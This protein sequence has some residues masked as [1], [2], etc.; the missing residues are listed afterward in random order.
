[1]YDAS[2][3]G[4]THTGLSVAGTM[5]ADPIEVRYTTQTL[6]VFVHHE[7]DQVRGYTGNVGHA[8]V[9]MSDLV[10][11]DLRRASANEGRFTSP[12]S[13]DDWDARANT[14]DKDG[15][16]TFAHLPADMDIVV[17]AEARDGY[18]LLDLETLDTYRNMGEN[19]VVGG[20]FGA[21][22]GWGHTVALCPLEEIEPTGQDFGDCASFGV[23]SLHGVTAD[24]SKMSVGKSGTGFSDPS[25]SRQ[26][27]VT[28]SLSPAEGKNLAGVG[29]SFTT[30]SS[31]DPSTPEDD[32]RAHNFGAMAAGSYELGLTDGW[33]AMA[34]D[35]KAA[36]ALDPLG[37]DVDI[38]VTPT[39]TTL[40]GF[41]RDQAGFGLKDVPV[42]VNGQA[43]A[44]DDLG[45]YLATG[46]ADAKGKINV[47][48]ARAG[49]PTTKKDTAFVA[50]M[51]TQLNITVS[52]AN[53]TVAITGTVT[54]SGT[55]APLK[56]VE[57][58]VD[59]NAPLN[60]TGGKLTT[61]DDG[62]YT[63]LVVT[64]P[65]NDPLVSVSPRKAGYHFIP[66]SSPV[67]A[68]AGAN[69][70][71]NFTGYAAT[72]IVG[73]VTAP[74]GGMPRAEVTVTAY[75]DADM[76][77][78]LDDA[79]TTE[80][81]TFSVF[82]PTLSGTVYL[83]AEPRDDY[84]PSHPNFLALRDAERY[85]WFDA[86]DNRPGG[87]IAVIPGQTLQFGTFTGNSVQ[88][89]IAS[90][91]RVT[92]RDAFEGEVAATAIT[93]GTAA[94]GRD[95][96]ETFLLVQGE[97]TDTVVVTWHYETRNN[98]GTDLDPGGVDANPYTAVDAADNAVLETALGPR[99]SSFTPPGGGVTTPVSAIRGTRTRG[100]PAGTPGRGT[101]PAANGTTVRHD[102]ITQ[103]IIPEGDDHDY[104]DIHITIGHPVVDADGTARDAA[105]TVSAAEALAGVASGASG[106]TVDRDIGGGSGGAVV[107]DEITASWSGAG[108][109][110]LET[111][112][113]LYV[114]VET[115]STT[116]NRWEWV[117][118][119]A[120]GG[121][122]EPAITR[123]TDPD[124]DSGS[125]WG[126]WNSADFDLNLPA[127]IVDNGWV[128]DDAPALQYTVSQ[129]RLRAATHL[130]VDTRVDNTGRWVKGTPVAI[131]DS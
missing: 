54:E 39:T 29:R 15:E 16:Y 131:P 62:T 98:T 101:T 57:I 73:R 70:S 116:E 96:D 115:G 33:M 72:E 65:N 125:D 71:A 93:P 31:N 112:I 67:A 77:D 43:V 123:D 109:P 119:P 80:T 87:Q 27:G 50:N 69:P 47:S 68:I 56:G 1:M 114:Q 2:G 46:V 120:T 94:R 124:T 95:G 40:Y 37:G 99:F 14:S 55:G 20:A 108:S 24:V 25:E 11:I 102:R 66:E 118:A 78:A 86:P 9:R 88:P 121:V 52:G 49:Y 61:G 63:A 21:M 12:I 122:T 23:V 91:R 30:A 22:G 28:V 51:P 58:R 19:G 100:T 32:R 38:V 90:V 130:R 8:D 103:Y 82:V 5:D 53:N 117:V 26:S 64:Q 36:D 89:R 75:A 110:Q 97:P 81:G 83:G 113:A 7:L 60:A 18:K 128:D 6:K 79:T 4:Y 106:V 34:G 3:G 48:I 76:T 92:I 13:S 35:M 59:G 17:R 127:N 10:D 74:G 85:T 42:E 126:K 129:A 45:R 104:R 111:R 84:D 107:T 44:T 41:V 105:A